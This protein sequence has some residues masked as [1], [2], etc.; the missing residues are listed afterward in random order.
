MPIAAIR[1]IFQGPGDGG[2]GLGSGVLKL[3]VVVILKT[4]QG[5]GTAVAVDG[6]TNRVDRLS[7]KSSR[8]SNAW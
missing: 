7:L 6:A 2:G 1:T 3:M 4:F 5:V 8:L